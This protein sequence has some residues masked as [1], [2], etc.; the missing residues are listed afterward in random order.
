MNQTNLSHLY[1]DIEQCLGLT[2]AM[3]ENRQ[4]QAIFLTLLSCADL[5]EQLLNREEALR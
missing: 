4:T 3:P 1:E 5:V 2:S